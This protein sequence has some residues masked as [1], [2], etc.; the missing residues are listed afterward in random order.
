MPA[1]PLPPWT[2]IRLP[3]TPPSANRH[4]CAVIAGTLRDAPTSKD[5]LSASLTD[6]TEGKT[7][8]SAAVPNALPVLM[9]YNPRERHC[10]G[11]ETSSG[12]DVGRIDAGGDDPHPDLPGS[13][14]RIG[15]R[16][17]AM[18]AKR[19]R[20]RPASFATIKSSVPFVAERQ[21]ETDETLASDNQH[22]NATLRVSSRLL[23]ASHPDRRAI[24]Q[25]R[26]ST[27]GWPRASL[28]MSTSLRKECCRSNS[29]AAGRAT[30]LPAPAQH[31]KWEIRR[32]GSR[33]G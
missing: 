28:P 15:R 26:S 6:C 31:P 5:T 3:R 16:R 18:E 29:S 20:G 10:L 19:Q 1:T 13:W 12:L 27:L 33:R 17:S 32:P 2:R 9:R 22:P 11:A 30:R 23:L 24:R 14:L 7:T 8:N 25:P 4:R 21:S